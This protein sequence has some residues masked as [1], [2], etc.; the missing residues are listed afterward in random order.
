MWYLSM[1]HPGDVRTLGIC[2][3]KW[4]LLAISWRAYTMLPAPI[5]AVIFLAQFVS[6]FCVATMVHNAMHCAVFAHPSVEFLWR[7]TLTTT[8]GFPTEAYKPTH[9]QNHHVFTQ[10]VEDHLHTTQ[11]SYKWQ[12]LNL[13]LFFPTVYPSIMKLE[14][15]YVKKEASKRSFNFFSFVCQTLCC[16]GWSIT[17]AII[18][19][20]RALTCWVLPNLLA[21]DG[22]VTMNMLQHDGCA[23]IQPG[24]NRGKDMEVNNSRNFVGPIINYITC[25]NGFHT[26]HHMESTTHWTRYPELHKKLIEP[27]NDP[28]LNQRCILRYLFKTYFCPGRRPVVSELRKP[29]QATSKSD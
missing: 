24:V 19:W 7:L 16:H 17:L 2:C 6:A 26:I 13:V 15:E 20:R 21:A 27:N 1:R 18:D 12:W 14:N 3:V 5:L 25:N 22:I 29:K 4:L 28:G 8:F 9:N 11:M 23:S 10:L